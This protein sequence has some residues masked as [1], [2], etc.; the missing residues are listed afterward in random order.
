MVSLVREPCCAGVDAFSLESFIAAYLLRID[1][2]VYDES[3]SDNVRK[4]KDS[5]EHVESGMRI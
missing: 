1:V 2:G 4:V 3:S 5:R